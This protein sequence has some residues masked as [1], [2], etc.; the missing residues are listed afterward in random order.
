[1]QRVLRKNENEIWT[2][3]FPGIHYLAKLWANEGFFAV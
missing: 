3:R 2:R 1:M